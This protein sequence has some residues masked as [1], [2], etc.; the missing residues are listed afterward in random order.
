MREQEMKRIQELQQRHRKSIASP[1]KKKEL[2]INQRVR[3]QKGM[4]G[5]A[6]SKQK[7][8]SIQSLIE[9][10]KE[11]GS[12]SKINGGYENGASPAKDYRV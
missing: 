4:L 6:K 11:A 7:F 5:E 2:L 10:H 12:P 1:N 8:K 3:K 9:E